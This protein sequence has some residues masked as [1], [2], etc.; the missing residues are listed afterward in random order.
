MFNLFNTKAS[1]Q[2][3]TIVFLSLGV[4]QTVYVYGSGGGDYLPQHFLWTW[5]YIIKK[6]N[7]SHNMSPFY[8]K[9][10]YDMQSK[11]S[12]VKV[13]SV[14]V[15]LIPKKFQTLSNSIIGNILLSI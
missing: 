12:F 5:I 7:S 3:A 2:N 15:V 14:R 13:W 4:L 9:Y 10:P 6:Q 11:G 8:N 1:L